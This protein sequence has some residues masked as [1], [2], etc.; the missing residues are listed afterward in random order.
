LIGF[1]FVFAACLFWALDT[2]IR[3]PLINNRLISATSIVFIEH[4]LLSAIFGVVFFKSLKRLKHIKRNHLVSFF[5]VGGIGSALATVAF[6]KAFSYLNPSLVILL[7]KFQ[8]VVAILLARLVLKERINLQFIFWAIV[9]LIGALLISS[10]DILQLL[11]PSSELH[12]Q[13]AGLGYALVSFSILGWGASTVFGKK[14]L[15]EGYKHEQV[16]GGRFLVG[17]IC[18]IPLMS[19]EPN[20]NIY[21]VDTFGKISLMVLVSGVLAMYLYYNGLRHISAR[22]CSLTELF[23]PFFAVIVNWIFL[24]AKLTLLQMVGGLVL[25]FGSIVIQL[26]KY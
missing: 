9:C 13:G 25:L 16:I 2:L 17:F 22:A 19:F 6:T 8:P 11:K 10:Q 4:L 21:S 7:Q 15:D 14:L 23:F 3:Y 20:I 5:V 18:L 1:L 12:F 26:K 24:D